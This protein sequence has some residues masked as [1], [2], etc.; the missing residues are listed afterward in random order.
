VGSVRSLSL[1]GRSQATGWHPPHPSSCPRRRSP[2]GSH[3]ALTSTFPPDLVDQVIE[4]TG[5]AEQRRRLLP[6]RVVVYWVLALALYGQAAHEEV[7]R[8]LVEG[9]GWGGADQVFDRQV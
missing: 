3:S 6:A 7:L 9:L 8:W 5:R 1:C 2:T 4:Q